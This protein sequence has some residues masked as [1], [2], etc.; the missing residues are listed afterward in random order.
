MTFHPNGRYLLSSSH[1]ST[2]KIWDLR[3]GLILY[4]LYGHEGHTNT[5]D[6]SPC[7]DYFTSSG[8][9][10]IVMVW[11]SNLNEI[12]QELIDDL[13]AKNSQHVPTSAMSAPKPASR[14]GVKGTA[15][16]QQKGQ[17]GADAAK[18]SSPTHKP[19]Q[20]ANVSY[21]PDPNL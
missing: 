2:V 14:A 21:K 7:G 3:Q 5:V 11:K 20:H 13:G 19:G 12:E 1:D 4:S 18:Q 17:T 8:Q 15:A 9:D 6:F 16:K 10:A